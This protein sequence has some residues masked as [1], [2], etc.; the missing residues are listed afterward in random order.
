VLTSTAACGG[1]RDA[2]ADA[3]AAARAAEC[4][5]GG[6]RA[7]D[8]AQWRAVVM[9]EARSAPGLTAVIHPEGA[10]GC[11]VL[12]V[13]SA[14]DRDTVVGRLRARAVPQRVARVVVMARVRDDAQLREPC[15]ERRVAL[16]GYAGV[17]R[18]GRDD[19]FQRLSWRAHSPHVN[20]SVR[21]LVASDPRVNTARISLSDNLVRS[22]A[23]H[24]CT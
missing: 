8:L 4:A 11:Y 14:A 2:D 10:T 12:G 17:R 7:G 20:L 1:T 18:R 15:T 6:L 5:D 9:E 24:R 23:P 19:H 16:N 21:R 3:F 13:A 22:F